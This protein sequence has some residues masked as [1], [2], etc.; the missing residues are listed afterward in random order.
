MGKHSGAVE[1][2]LVDVPARRIYPARV[3]WDQGIIHSLEEL[4]SAPPCYLLPGFV[5]AH[6]H[7]ESS[8]LTPSEFGRAALPHGTV[9]TVSDPH[10]IANVLGEAGIEFMLTE[11]ERSPLKFHFGVPS[12]VPATEFETAGG[13][14]DCTLVERLIQDPRL[15]YL[16]EMMNFPGVLR[17]SPEVLAKIRATQLH[18]KPV[19]GHAPG[20]RGLDAI[21][22]FSHGISTDHECTS[23]AEAREKAGL[24]V[25]ILIREGSAA[26]NFDALLP[27]VSEQP[28]LCMFCSDDLHPDDLERG[29]IQRLVSRGAK[30]GIDPFLL[31]Q[32]ACHNPVS[33]YRLNVGLLRP[34]DCADFI[35]VE[36]LWEFTVRQ[37]YVDGRLVA[38]QGQYLGGHPA[39]DSGAN[40]DRLNIFRAEVKSEEAYRISPKSSQVRVIEATDGLLTTGSSIARLSARHGNACSDTTQDV[41]KL[42]VVNRYQDV[43]PSLAFVRGFGLKQGA[44]ASSVAHDCHNIVAVGVS[45]ED[46]CQAVNAVISHR[47]GLAACYGGQQWVLPLPIA[48]LMSF[49][50]CA[51]VASQYAELNR[52]AHSWGSPLRAPFMTL[53]FM[54]LLVIPELKLSDRGLFDGT[55][56]EFVECFLY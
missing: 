33:H 9:A 47:G 26:R 24:G 39:G 45:D 4:A 41:L 40:D 12:C 48:G 32:A 29:H 19:D 25:S 31:L 17:D 5:D 18:G 13:R 2:Q 7:I 53:A 43:A 27:L 44:L 23:L 14:L 50:P 55:R 6:I 28:R 21:R 51:T 54:A 34:G 46:L 22:Y 38:Q 20:L 10:E 36:D 1:G 15:G 49:Q 52:V 35:V 11:A 37:T 8:M 30:K 42:A 16:S 3:V 56:M